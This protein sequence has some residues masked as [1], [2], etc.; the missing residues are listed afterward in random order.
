MTESFANTVPDQDA[1]MRD[2]FAL[3]KPRV[4]SLVIFTAIVGIFVAPVEVH[5]IIA[6]SS[7]LFIALGAGASGAL[8]M[9]WDAD[10]DKIMYRTRNRPIPSGKIDKDDAR[11][12]GLWLTGLSV[13]MLALT[14]NFMAAFLLAFTIFFYVV[15]YTMY[16]KRITAQ[17]IVIGGAA[18]ALP[19]VIGWTVATAEITIEPVLLF[20]LIFLW[21]PPHF[22]SLALYSNDD[23]QKAGLPML[24]V[25]RGSACTRRHILYYCLS[26]LPISLIL[27][28][29]SIGG[30]VTA[31]FAII[32]NFVFIR[33]AFKLY[34]RN[35]TVANLDGYAAEKQFFKLSLLFLFVL[36]SSLVVDAMIQNGTDSLFFWPMW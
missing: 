34:Y 20:I 26:L 36:F 28:F 2:L 35:D 19:P 29:S 1:D 18:G 27:S 12:I 16:L 13:V 11:L 7:V 9:W 30:P 31:L 17:N 23:Y 8:N 25:T 6:C 22:W 5:P 21:T 24:P 32:T 15:I 14:A 3:L 10:I 33:G 4:M